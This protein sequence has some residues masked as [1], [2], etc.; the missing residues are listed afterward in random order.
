[1]PWRHRLRSDERF[2][3]VNQIEAAAVDFQIFAQRYVLGAFAVREREIEL[4]A[5]GI[6]L[7]PVDAIEQT[8]GVHQLVDHLLLARRQT[9]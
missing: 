1:M 8:G 6:A 9:L 5:F 7:P 3:I 2:L 4:Q